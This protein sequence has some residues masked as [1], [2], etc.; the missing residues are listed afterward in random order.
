MAN[1]FAGDVF[2]RK[3][4]CHFFQRVEKRRVDAWLDQA[5]TL[6]LTLVTVQMSSS[7]KYLLY[8]TLLY[9]AA[10]EKIL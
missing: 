9:S 5:S 6:D 8:S 4:V 1:A 3:E 2:Y 10:H 7:T